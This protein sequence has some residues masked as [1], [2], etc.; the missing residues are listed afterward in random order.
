MSV[1]AQGIP[2]DLEMTSY[3][4][5]NQQRLLSLYCRFVSKWLFREVMAALILIWFSK[6]SY[7]F[8]FVLV[9]CV[10]SVLWYIRQWKY[11]VFIVPCCSL[12][13]IVVL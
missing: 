4:F 1:R 5:Y 2:M 10:T 9:Y 11:L 7:Y 12:L 8:R 3:T 6:S 13:H